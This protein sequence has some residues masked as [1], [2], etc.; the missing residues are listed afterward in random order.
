MSAGLPKKILVFGATGVIGKF[1]LQEIVNARSS[2][3]KIGL[4][5]SPSTVENKSQ[6]M[7]K[8]KDEGVNIIVGDVSSEEDV[9]KAYEGKSAVHREGLIL[10]RIVVY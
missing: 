4:F 9:K 8:W 3:D 7:Q 1:I 10:I 6:E 2:F 5:T